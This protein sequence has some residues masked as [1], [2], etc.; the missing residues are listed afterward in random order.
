[1]GDALERELGDA[2]VLI[3]AAAVS[4]FLVRDPSARKIK[5]GDRDTLEIRLEA[6]PD[7]LAATRALREAGGVLTL[8]FALETDDPIA[9]AQRKL[10]E[11]GL[12]IVAVN[13]AG[14]ADRGVEAE[15]NQVT[16]I[17]AGGVVEELP[18]LSKAEVAE[19]LL[20]HLEDRVAMT[21]A[22]DALRSYLEGRETLGRARD[23]PAARGA[24]RRARTPPDGGEG[25]SRTA[26]P[27]TRTSSA[28]RG[29][30]PGRTSWGSRTWVACVTSRRPARGADCTA[31]GPGWCSPMEAPTRD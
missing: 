13:E 30:A 5:R 24:G 28:S 21:E 6:G 18:L 3:M 11:K 27:A 31:P 25:S 10:V 15:T 9:N 22:R 17:D 12:D 8:G 2:A 26:R 7:L 29:R 16:L 4:D 19:R 1:M 14:R 20:D 23:V